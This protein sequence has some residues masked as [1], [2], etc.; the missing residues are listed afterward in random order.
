MNEFLKQNIRKT[1]NFLGYEIISQ[2]RLTALCSH[3]MEA[4][5]ARSKNRGIEIATVIDVGASDG[6][7]SELC[8]KH[9]PD[10]F[11]L[12][13]EAQQIHEPQLMQFIKKHPKSDY[14]IS[15][16]GNTEGDIYFDAESAVGG[17]AS[18]TPFEKHCIKVPVTTIDQIIIKKQLKPP[19]L[20]KLDT[21]GYEVPI[22]EGTKDTLT[23]T[24]LIIIE[25]YNFKLT[26]DSFLFYEMCDY[27]EKRGF[28]PIDMVDL[29][30]RKHDQSLWQMDLF[31]LPSTRKEFD[32]K[33]YE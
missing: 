24:N 16:A 14:L 26:Q 31:F 27:M 2:Q 3:S 11:Y 23:K 30:Q 25:T 1:I 29:M 6:S 28:L 13:I 22:L 20:I 12:L 5:I 21:H 10:A 8:L 18:P 4:A 17:L 33:A 32:Y 19:Y 9:Y 7:W 15:A